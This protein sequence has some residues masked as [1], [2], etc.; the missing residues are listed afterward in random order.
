MSACASLKI[1]I[2]LHRLVDAYATSFKVK[3]NES[4]LSFLMLNLIVFFSTIN[5]TEFLLRDSSKR[6]RDCR[7][8]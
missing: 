2:K 3:K 7:Y 4:S 1:E 6:W 8:T 5:M